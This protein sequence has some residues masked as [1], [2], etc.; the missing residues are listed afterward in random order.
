VGTAGYEI[1]RGLRELWEKKK[2]RGEGD[3]ADRGGTENAYGRGS[4][5]G[6]GTCLGGSC[7]VLGNVNRE[8]V[9]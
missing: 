4:M 1:R 5:R 6:L 3:G 7:L 9:E 8:R 2:G